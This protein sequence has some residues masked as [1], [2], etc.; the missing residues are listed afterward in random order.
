M[1]EV[2]PEVS[3]ANTSSS[4]ARRDLEN[5]PSAEG[6]R[7][8]LSFIDGR[9]ICPADDSEDL[10]EWIRID[11]MGDMTVTA[12][13]TKIK[14]LWDELVCLDPIP[15]CVCAVHRQIIAR[16]DS[17]QLMRFLMGLNNTYEHMRSQIL[18]MDPRP[19]VQKA[20]SM[21]LSVEKQLFVQVQ[22]SVGASGAVYHLNHKHSKQRLDK[23]SMLCD[24]CKKTGHLK[25]NCFKLHGTPDWYKELIDK[26]K[27]G[28][29]RGKGFVATIEAAPYTE[30]LRTKDA[31]L[32][33]IVRS[34]IRKIMTEDESSQLQQRTPF[35]DIRVNFAHHLQDIDESAGN[36]YYFSVI[37]CGTWIIDSGAT[38]HVCADINLFTHYYKP[39]TSSKVTL[40]DGTKQTVAHIGNVKLSD[41]II[42]EHV[43]HIP[44]FS[45]NLLSDLW[46]KRELALGKL[47]GGL[48]T[49][50]NHSFTR[51]HNSVSIPVSE[52]FVLDQS[53]LWHQR[54]GHASI[55]SLKHIP[56]IKFKNLSHF[57]PC[58]VC[59]FAKQQRLPS[60]SG[61]S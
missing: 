42:L 6:A 48:Y 54:L 37:D 34:E 60:H 30:A 36:S 8:K 43:L 53:V 4:R 27:K 2:L 18:L 40:P 44:T 3:T 22:H 52:S 45:V 51:P 19:H 15:S 41:H 38:R 49:L 13:F 29:G 56:S 1:A 28:V 16:E 14:M 23:C 35:D 25:E 55:E 33:T 11:Y 39:N 5:P 61:E 7:K 10:D 21:V 46:T 58:D 24:Y 12:Y 47:V 20:F 32:S 26:K 59:H 9:S 57:R 17:R 31:E 50:D